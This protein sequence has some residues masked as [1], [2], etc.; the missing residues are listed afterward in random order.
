[1]RVLLLI[2][3]SGFYGAEAVVANLSMGLDRL[4]C[5]AVVGSL[6]NIHQPGNGFEER[7]EELRIPLERIPC[8]RRVDPACAQRI[9]ELLSSGEFDVLHTH[10]YKADFHGAWAARHSGVR[11]IA[12]CHNWIATDLRGRMYDL[13][14]RLTLRSFRQVVAVSGPVSRSLRRF[15]I[16]EDRIHIIPNG[17]DIRR[18]SAASVRAQT[19]PAHEGPVLGFIGRLSDEKGLDLLLRAIPGILRRYPKTVLLVAG[20]GAARTRLEAL[21]A[22]LGVIGSVRFLGR[23]DD[24]EA[25]YTEFDVLALPSRN[26][27]A[28]MTVLEAMAAG[29]P[30]LATRVGGVPEIVR[31][32]QTGVLVDPNSV[33]AIEQGLIALLAAPDLRARM[34]VEARKLAE[35]RHSCESMAREYMELYCSAPAEAAVPC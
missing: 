14:D 11:L 21:A 2:S 28:P 16:P 3:S 24:I 1:M 22:D 25:I 23:R 8:R 9:R 7:I 13:L 35:T 12:T 5:R 10:G 6:R 30:V 20:D 31:E 19:A 4:G 33:A 17:V 34:R 15:G 27:G 32:G 18:F 29:V 26:E